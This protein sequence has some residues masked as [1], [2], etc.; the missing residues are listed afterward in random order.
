M[1][2]QIYYSVFV[3]LHES[4][5]RDVHVDYFHIVNNQLNDN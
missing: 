1:E 5:S 2:E 4:T 3:Q